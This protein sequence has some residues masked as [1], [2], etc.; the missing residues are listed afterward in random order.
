MCRTLTGFPTT[1]LERAKELKS[2]LSTLL[3]KPDQRK[4]YRSGKQERTISEDVQ[5]WKESFDALLSSPNGIAAF[6]AFLKTEFSEENLDFWLACEEFKKIRSASKLEAQARRIFEEFVCCE[7]PKE[8][9]LDHE[10]R[11]LTRAGLQATPRSCFDAAQFKT[12]TL[13]EKD[14]YPRFLRSPAY[15]DLAKGMGVLCC[16]RP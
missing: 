3:H 5:G 7:A 6:R 2:R 1:C 15:R 9:N 8:V 16:S 12:R 10:T 4:A 11:E 14:S 13:M